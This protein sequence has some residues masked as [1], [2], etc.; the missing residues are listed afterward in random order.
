MKQFKVTYRLSSAVASDWQAD[1]I[2]GH[3]CWALRY[4]EGEERLIRFLN[5]YDGEQT[6]LI[7]SNGFPAD[8]LPRPIIPPFPSLERDNRGIK[9]QIEGFKANK[10]ARD[11]TLLSPQEFMQAIQGQEVLPTPKREYPPYKSSTMKNQINRLTGTTGAEGSLYEFEETIWSYREDNRVVGVPISIYVKVREDFASQAERLFSFIATQGYGKRKSVGY[12][13][14]RSCSFEPFPEFKTVPEANGFVSL[15]NFV[16][17]HNDPREGTWHTIVKYGKLGEEYAIG[18]NPFKRPLLMFTA[19]SCF[20]DAPGRI[21]YGRMV[22]DIAA[23]SHPEVVQ[24]GLAFPV[25]IK[26]PREHEGQ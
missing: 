10:D 6:P 18:G 24:Y 26:L 3:L 23:P 14:I 1:T 2:F 4:L 25:P 17:A 8:L 9:Q 22:R 11:I 19:G 15:S 13:Q 16:P 7:I 20:Y 5:D 12:G 21:H